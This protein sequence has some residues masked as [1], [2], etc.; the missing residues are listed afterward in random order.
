MHA[1]RILAK[2]CVVPREW[3]SAVRQVVPQQ[4]QQRH[5]RRRIDLGHSAHIAPVLV[6]GSGVG[7]P[8][9]RRDLLL[10]RGTC[11]RWHRRR[12]RQLTLQGLILPPQQLNM[13]RIAHRASK[14]GGEEDIAALDSA[15]QRDLRG[16]EAIAVAIRPVLG[17]ADPQ[18]AAGQ[19]LERPHGRAPPPR[20]S[21]KRSSRGPSLPL[22]PWVLQYNYTI[23]RATVQ[24]ATYRT[25][26]GRIGTIL[27]LVPQL[28]VPVR[29]NMDRYGPDKSRWLGYF[30]DREMGA[31]WWWRGLI[32][33][34]RRS[35]WR[36][37]RG[38]RGAED[39]GRR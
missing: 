38:E 26:S 37:R 1:R 32:P 13:L 27:V 19:L 22:L 20:G 15:L 3:Q 30:G 2:R 35:R 14:V 5:E 33:P 36:R 18:A 9:E 8:D 29:V 24:V 21:T 28:S 16:I 4:Y 7:A 23:V 11:A 34:F 39:I 31:I 6:R 12:V 17:A 25:V 10:H